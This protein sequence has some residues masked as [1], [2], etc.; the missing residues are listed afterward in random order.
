MSG[1]RESFRMW[2]SPSCATQTVMKSSGR[3]TL[4]STSAWNLV[5]ASPY[6]SEP[7]NV[8]LWR[9][10]EPDRSAHSLSLLPLRCFWRLHLPQHCSSDTSLH[11]LQQKEG[12]GCLEAPSGMMRPMMWLCLARFCVP[13][14]MYP[15]RSL[16]LL[17]WIVGCFW[18][19]VESAS[20]KERSLIIRII[21]FIRA[22]TNNNFDKWLMWLIYSDR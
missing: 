17:H 2:C 7:P 16:Q 19:Q 11:R 21:V 14:L 20:V 3:K 15:I 9:R 22:A 8:S 4:T 6:L 10:P 12:G 1:F 18:C 5:R 13:T